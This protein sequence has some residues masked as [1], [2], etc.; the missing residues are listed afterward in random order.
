MPKKLNSQEAFDLCKSFREMSV[1]LGNYRFENWDKMSEEQRN[2]MENA[3]S[4]LLITSAKIRTVAVGLVLDETQIN[5]VKLLKSTS[6]AKDILK[7]LDDIHKAIVITTAI[8][9]LAGAIVSKDL[10]DIA[11]TAEEFYD[12][13]KKA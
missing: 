13:I 6:E 1:S 3:E 8:V 5:Y 10:G 2:E 4:S 7:Q 11:K 9:S 12:A